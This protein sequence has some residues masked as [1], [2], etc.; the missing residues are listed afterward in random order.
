MEILVNKIVSSVVQLLLFACIPFLWWL[1]TA[2]KRIGFFQW[3]GFVFVNKE[4]RKSSL[5]YTAIV[6]ISFTLV[7]T[8]ILHV[9]SGTETA[10]SDFNG[11][12]IKALP[13]ALI[14][15]IF[16]TALPEELLFRGFLLKRIAHRFGFIVGNMVQSILFG[17]LHGV[18]F[19]SI[20]GAARAMIIILF[21][22]GI[23][24]AIGYINEVKSNGSILPGWII[25]A[26]SN[27]FSAL[28][29][30]FSLI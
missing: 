7:S 15:A 14:Y 29:A 2:R 17:L 9:I 28:V 5:L 12:G 19:F 11:L 6:M 10:T 20:T 18:M 4:N 27:L 24:F 8:F 1:I 16:N 21:T 26:V 23:A 13:A 22:G 30:M 25:H 3:I